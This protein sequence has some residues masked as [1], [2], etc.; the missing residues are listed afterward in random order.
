MD[1]KK[2]VESFSREELPAL[3]NAARERYFKE[4]AAANDRA[5]HRPQY[6]PVAHFKA[7]TR[8]FAGDYELPLEVVEQVVS[9]MQGGAPFIHAV[10]DFRNLLS[11][12]LGR[13]KILTDRL[14]EASLLATPRETP[15]P[16]HAVNEEGDCAPWCRGCQARQ[17]S[18]L[19]LDHEG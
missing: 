10:R 7:F 5:S 2:L 9:V 8:R 11:T 3:F 19:P 15:L 12:D 14:I 13:A 1:F 6:R 18:G 16:G 17:D 4:Y